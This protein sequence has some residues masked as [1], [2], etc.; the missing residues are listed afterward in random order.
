M[1]SGDTTSVS[2]E[3]RFYLLHTKEAA[4]ENG[5]CQILFW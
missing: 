4:V 1:H 5:D 2:Y 3:M